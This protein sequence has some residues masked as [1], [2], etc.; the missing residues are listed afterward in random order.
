MTAIEARIGARRREGPAIDLRD[1]G[2]TPAAAWRAIERPG[3]RIAS[4]APG[5]L[6]HAVG[7]IEPGMALDL[8]EALVAAARSGGWTA[9][10]TRAW[11]A[12]RARAQTAPA[13]TTTLAS[14]RKR[15]A[16]AERREAEFRERV[17]RTRGRVEAARD[18]GEDPETAI[19]DLRERV[20]DLAAAETERIAAEQAL[21]RR[22]E[23]ARALRRERDRQRRLA[24]RADN[25]ERAVR[26]HL[27]DGVYE[28][29]ADAVECVPGSAATGDSPEAFDGPAATAAMAA[30]RTGDPPAPI[31]VCEALFDDAVTAS[32]RLDAPVVLVDGAES[33]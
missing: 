31:V 7:V 28:S 5:P 22:R 24:D 1:T 23:S 10:E 19:G 17:T 33:F 6:H 25:L 8:R 15:V 18:T 21:D 3:G 26:Q 2:L 27:V 4:P 11:L 30:V 16:T 32:R 13:E 29:V 9:P 20:G 14:A 12:A